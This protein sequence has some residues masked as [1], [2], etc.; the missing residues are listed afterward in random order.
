MPDELRIQ[1]FDRLYSI[2][3]EEFVHID[4][5]TGDGTFP[6]T[7]F[8]IYNRYSV[9]VSLYF[10]FN[11]LTTYYF[12]TSRGMMLIQS[13]SLQHIVVLARKK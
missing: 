5:S 11:I 1:L 9:Q 2:F 7:Y 10:Y 4:S 6:C 8:T 12:I 3:P 13:K